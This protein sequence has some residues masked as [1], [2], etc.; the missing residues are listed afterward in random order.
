[1]KTTWQVSRC[2]TPRTGKRVVWGTAE[3]IDS[4]EPTRWF[5]RVDLPTF[6]RPA[7]ATN[8]LV[9]P[10]GAAV[11]AP[12]LDRSPSLTACP[13][14]RA[15]RDAARR[16]DRHPRAERDGP[17]S[18]RPRGAEGRAPGTASSRHRSRDRTPSG[19]I[20]RASCRERVESAVVA[21]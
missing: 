16:P 4:F 8:P 3:T 1:M 19:E 21:G 14:A 2:R 12:S 6:A 7:M 11:F 18:H 17:G 13:P 15:W 9:K 5:I 20:G 10:G